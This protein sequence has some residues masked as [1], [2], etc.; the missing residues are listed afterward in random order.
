MYVVIVVV[1]IVGVSFLFKGLTKKDLKDSLVAD[2]VTVNGELQDVISNKVI[3]EVEEMK[4][5]EAIVVVEAPIITDELVNYIN[6][7]DDVN[8][9]QLLSLINNLVETKEPIVRQFRMAYVEQDELRI[10]YTE[11]YVNAV[12]CGLYD[13]Y[14][15]MMEDVIAELEGNN[16]EE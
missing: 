16:E 7:V 11:E 13:F 10:G 2:A 6:S 3:I 15:I 9:A 1:L 4:N 12:S 14:Q 8:D 5:G